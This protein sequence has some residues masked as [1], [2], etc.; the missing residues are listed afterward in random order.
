[1]IVSNLKKK[2]NIIKCVINNIGGISRVFL[3][4]PDIK[5]S[6]F[7]TSSVNLLV[8]VSLYVTVTHSSQVYH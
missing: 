1:M 5:R 7:T 3:L 4:F 8:K 6:Y 2:P